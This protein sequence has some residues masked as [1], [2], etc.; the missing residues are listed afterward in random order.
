[1]RQIRATKHPYPYLPPT[2]IDPLPDILVQVLTSEPRIL[3]RVVD[4][5]YE[6]VPVSRARA[7][8]AIAYLACHPEGVTPSR[9]AV[10]LQPELA[11]GQSPPERASTFGTVLS[12]ARKTLGSDPAGNLYF[13]NKT[14]NR[15]R[16]TNNVMLDWHVLL[17]LRETA[18]GTPSQTKISLLTNALD[19]LDDE[20][21]LAETRRLGQPARRRNRIEYWRWF[22]IEH[23]GE[24]ERAVTDIARDLPTQLQL[25]WKEVERVFESEGEPYEHVDD[26]LRQHYRDLL[27]DV[28]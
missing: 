23:L 5:R 18:A 15:L 26:E 27:H 11:A 6:P 7:L 22:Q 28:G 21:P 9:L 16:L 10:A 17:R 19:L 14:A 25:A 8:E 20:T 3:R 1:V 2:V 24:I 4:D 12:A 13:P